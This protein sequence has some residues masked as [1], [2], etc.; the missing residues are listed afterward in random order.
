[1]QTLLL[2]HHSVMVDLSKKSRNL[3]MLY[4]NIHVKYK[5]E[6]F[7]KI[8]LNLSPIA[9]S[10]FFSQLDFD[11]DF[12]LHQS[13]QYTKTYAVCPSAC[14]MD[15]CLTSFSAERLKLIL[16]AYT[17]CQNFYLKKSIKVRSS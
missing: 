8:I 11:H 1:M 15:I 13:D 12:I 17:F 2:L 6:F 7:C 14:T 3:K 5:P 16:C 4:R 10:Y 9:Y